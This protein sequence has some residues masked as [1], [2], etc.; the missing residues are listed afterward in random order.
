M[1]ACDTERSP[2]GPEND[3]DDDD[4]EEPYP[5]IEDDGIDNEVVYIR[6]FLPYTYTCMQ[7]S[8]K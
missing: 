7:Y 8:P 3:G 6:M 4:D 2:P 5:T 1:C